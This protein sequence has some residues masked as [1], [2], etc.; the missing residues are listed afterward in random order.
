MLAEARTRIEAFVNGTA[1]AGG[2]LLRQ[3][4]AV[5]LGRG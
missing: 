5:N 1:P 4:G 2:P 3:G